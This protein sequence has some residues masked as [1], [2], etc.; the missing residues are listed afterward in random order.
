M[1]YQ[2]SIVVPVYNKYNFTK[3]CLQDLFKLPTDTHEIIVF[4]NG[5]SDETQVELEKIKDQSN[6][7]YIRSEL[8]GGFAFACNRGYHAASAPNVLFL[9][10]DIRVKKDYQTWTQPLL[11]HCENALVGPTMGQLDDRFN[12]VKEANGELKGPFVYM[13]GWCLASSKK[14]LDRLREK[15]YIGP[16]SEDFFCYFEDANL[17]ISAARL[18][19]PFK[20]VS[21]PVVHF[22]KV[23]SQQLNT[24]NL[25]IRAKNI[26]TEKWR[27]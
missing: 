8:N 21:I 1:S 27:K 4:D 24:Y 16:F 2:L 15:N 7:R 6:F 25:Y 22:G 5:S 3:S 19:I 23:S 18:N 13:S 12:F 20:V 17:G 9:N 11:E 10:N 14:I 26:F